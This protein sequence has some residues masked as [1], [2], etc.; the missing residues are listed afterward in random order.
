VSFGFFARLNIKI[1]I[2]NT[3]RFNPKSALSHEKF[4]AEI[5]KVLATL[6]TINIKIK[7]ENTCNIYLILTFFSR[8]PS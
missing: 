7:I 4:C 5:K 3:S 6:C 8:I 1:E 2:E